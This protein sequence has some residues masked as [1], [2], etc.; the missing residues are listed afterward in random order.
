VGRLS[1]GSDSGRR[2]LIRTD[3]TRRVHHPQP[4]RRGTSRVDH[5]SRPRSR[6]TATRHATPRWTQMGQPHS[7]GAR[8]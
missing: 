6:R 3:G 5:L 1:L 8:L 2:L 7:V 4:A